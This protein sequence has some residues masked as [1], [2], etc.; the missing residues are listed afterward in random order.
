MVGLSNQNNV[1][2]GLVTPMCGMAQETEKYIFD[3]DSSIED[4]P[5]TL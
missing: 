3:A 1:L 2:R 5:A 4:I